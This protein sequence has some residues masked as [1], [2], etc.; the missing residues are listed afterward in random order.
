VHAH[1]S[2]A[3][4]GTGPV[5]IG[6]SLV[7]T[8]SSQ[9]INFTFEFVLNLTNASIDFHNV[10]IVA[11]LSWVGTSALVATSTSCSTSATCTQNNTQFPL[12]SAALGAAWGNNNRSASEVVPFKVTTGWLASMGF[13]GG[14]WPQGLYNLTVDIWAWN[15]SNG[16]IPRVN[17]FGVYGFFLQTT[18]LTVTDLSSSAIQTVPYNFQYEL[19]LTNAAIDS[20]NVSL[21]AQIVWM[22][23]GCGSGS[24]YG[25]FECPVLATVNSCASPCVTNATQFA[26]PTAALDTSCAWMTRCADEVLNWSINSATLNSTG[27]FTGTPSQYAQGK[28]QINIYVSNVG[29]SSNALSAFITPERRRS[30]RPPPAIRSSSR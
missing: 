24:I 17:F 27:V 8:A 29:N 6:S 7:T 3:A 28:Y 10:S 21:T 22:A 25:G 9:T 16:A 20:N 13:N 2:P 15:S 11:N 26:L 4:A 18:V 12:P 14:N 1:A 30:N 23:P 5:S 19:N